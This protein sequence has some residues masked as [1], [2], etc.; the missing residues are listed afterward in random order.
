M[1]CI[2]TDLVPP[3][4]LRCTDTMS[5]RHVGARLNSY[6]ESRHQLWVRRCVLGLQACI[7]AK[8]ARSTATRFTM[9]STTYVRHVARLPHGA[10]QAIA[11]Q[12]FKSVLVSAKLDSIDWKN[13][14]T[15]VLK[16]QQTT[17]QWV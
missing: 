13:V 9:N 14:A 12:Q 8:G 16:K 3:M 15:F 5:A 7:H 4:L 10:L 17:G 6:P 1:L 11:N 2:H